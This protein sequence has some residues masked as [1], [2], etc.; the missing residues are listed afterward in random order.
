LF[1]LDTTINGRLTFGTE[2]LN[3]AA[4]SGAR[5]NVE[6]TIK[7]RNGEVCPQHKLQAEAQVTATGLVIGGLIGISGL[8]V[9]PSVKDE[10]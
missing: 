9:I 4:A 6:G 5:A 8:S 1:H 2:R 10:L 3:F 7:H